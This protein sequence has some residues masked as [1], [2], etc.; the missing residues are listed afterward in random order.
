MLLVAIT[1]TK[2]SVIPSGI[3]LAGPGTLGATIKGPSAKAT[4]AGPDGSVISGVADAGAVVAAP[5]PGGVVTASV[6]PGFVAQPLA[7]AAPVAVAAPL[8]SKYGVGVPLGG[9][10]IAGPSGTVISQP[11]LGLGVGAWNT[12]LGWTSNALVSPAY[13]KT[14][15][16]A[17]SYWGVEPAW[18]WGAKDW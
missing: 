9:A 16:A 4:V 14:V 12:G 18:K 17:P 6:T 1:A 10:V 3:A 15:V 13:A 5:L 11:G 7:V 8:V 2:S